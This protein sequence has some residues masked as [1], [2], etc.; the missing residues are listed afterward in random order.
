MKYLGLAY[1]DR[2]KMESLSKEESRAIGEECKPY[3][4]EF[5]KSGRVIVHEGLDWAATSL[6]PRQGA[7]CVIDGPFV[8]TK[9]QVGGVFIIEA[10][11]FNEAIRVASLHPAAHLG[12]QLGWGIEL[13]PLMILE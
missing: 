13:R 12:E 1:G 10:R 11:D 7:V 8:E 6:L 5:E 4:A 3:E 2:G 9:E